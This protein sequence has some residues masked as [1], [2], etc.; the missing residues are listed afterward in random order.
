MMVKKFE[1]RTIKEA[2]DLVKKEFGPDA[3]ILNVKDRSHKFGLLS[4]PSV[5][6]TAAISSKEKKNKNSTISISNQT[7]KPIERI[8]KLVTDYGK[9]EQNSN[10]KEDLKDLNLIEESWSIQDLKSLENFQRQL[11]EIKKLIESLVSRNQDAE[12]VTTKNDR[13]YLVEFQERLIRRGLS[14]R[15]AHE[16]ATE[17]KKHIDFNQLK[18]PVVESYFLSWLNQN[19]KFYKPIHLVHFFTGLQGSGKT[20]FMFK[21]AYWLKSQFNKKLAFVVFNQTHPSSLSQIRLVADILQA[22]FIR[23]NHLSE[24]TEILDQIKRYDFVLV[25]YES[26]DSSMRKIMDNF[27]LSLKKNKISYFWH[28]I[29]KL[30][31]DGKVLDT[32][33]S[34]PDSAKALSFTNADLTSQLASI[35]DAAYYL[36]GSIFGISYSPSY[37]S[38]FEPLSVERI[39]DFSLN[40]SRSPFLSPIEEQIFKP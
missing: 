9:L 23:I 3:I 28:L 30:P 10:E 13:N 25:D 1:A 39:F 26:Y 19:L 2:L 32:F 20:T 34:F 38:G 6:V 37:V 11:N 14:V 29:L 16:I 8:K 40:I 18:K 33:L 24:F 5:E 22:T 31:A 36:E 7:E 17:I 27:I 21:M 15:L 12:N 4:Q 35:I